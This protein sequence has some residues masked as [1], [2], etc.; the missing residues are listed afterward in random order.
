MSEETPI[1]NMAPGLLQAFAP[2]EEAPQ[3]GPR[4]R[5]RRG[6]DP[7]LALREWQPRTRLGQKVMAGEIVSYEQALAA[8]LVHRIGSVFGLQVSARVMHVQKPPKHA[9]ARLPP[10]PPPSQPAAPPAAAEA[11]AAEDVS[12]VVL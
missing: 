9:V 4:R 10:Q 12:H 5:R 2:Q 7:L 3:D 1:Q 6:P 8:A 11:E